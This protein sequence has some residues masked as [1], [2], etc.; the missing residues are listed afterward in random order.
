MLT[1][2]QQQRAVACI[3]SSAAGSALGAGYE[4][5]PPLCASEA[6]EMRASELWKRGEWTGATSTAIGILEALAR[7]DSP[8][9]PAALGRLGRRWMEWALLAPDVG[10]TVDWVF[11]GVDPELH[12]DGQLAEILKERA[13]EHYAGRMRDGEM[14]RAART[15]NG[16]LMRTHA[17]ALAPLAEGEGELADAA[18][19][20]SGLTHADEDSG[21]ACVLWTLACRAAILSGRADVRVGLPQLDAERRA[22]WEARIAACEGRHPRDVEFNAGCVGALQAAWAAITYARAQRE[23]GVDA[24]RLTLQAAVRGGRDTDAVAAIAGALVGAEQGVAP[25]RDEL[26]GWPGIGGA[27]LEKL[28]R[29][30]LGQH[31]QEEEKLE[32]DAPPAYTEAT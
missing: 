22:V 21:D 12:D 32:T 19:A 30:A 26:R 29:D 17:L 25:W 6:V 5:K 7:G 8:L 31:R 1:A 15:G 9:S 18:R 27:E 14:P 28:A 2:A 20:V 23:G 11:S 3:L 10:N 4:F 13:G 24:V 16:S